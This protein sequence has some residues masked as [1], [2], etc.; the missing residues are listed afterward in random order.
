MLTTNSQDAAIQQHWLNRFVWDKPSSVTG[1]AE[2]K[3]RQY[4]MSTFLNIWGNISLEGGLHVY[5]IDSS[6]CGNRSGLW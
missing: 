2:S 4:Q 5:M 3:V 6:T 1:S